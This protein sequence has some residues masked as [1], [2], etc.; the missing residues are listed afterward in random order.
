MWFSE[1]PIDALWELKYIADELLGA[2]CNNTGNDTNTTEVC[3]IELYF[4]PFDCEDYGEDYIYDDCLF[5]W[6]HC[7]EEVCDWSSND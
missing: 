7:T 2:G 3:D 6:D 4:S 5:F 1:F